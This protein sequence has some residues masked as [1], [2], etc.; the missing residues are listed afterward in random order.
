[1]STKP[2]I[3]A[4][5]ITDFSVLLKQFRAYFNFILPLTDLSDLNSDSLCQPS[6]ERTTSKTIFPPGLRQENTS[7][8]I[9]RKIS[10]GTC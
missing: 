5:S 3:S 2:D 7:R 8:R 4:N 10:S 6:F 9:L 1:M